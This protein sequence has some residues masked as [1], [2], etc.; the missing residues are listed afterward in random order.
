[1]TAFKEIIHKRVV[2][3][4]CLRQVHVKKITERKKKRGGGVAW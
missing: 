4:T 1:M 2:L 3:F